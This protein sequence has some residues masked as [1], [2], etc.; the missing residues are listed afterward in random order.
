[1]FVTTVGVVGSA[2][3]VGVV[4]VVAVASVD[5]HAY[6]FVMAVVVGGIGVLWFGFA[7]A[8]NCESELL[9]SFE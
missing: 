4:A 2:G 5:V 1:M 6:L 7:I 8:L 9:K 3:V